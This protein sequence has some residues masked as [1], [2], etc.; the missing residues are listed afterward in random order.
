MYRCFPIA[1][2]LTSFAAQSVVGQPSLPVVEEV[3]WAPFRD[4]CR[5]LLQPLNKNAS[6]LPSETV[7]QLRT[8]VERNPDD[9]AAASA[10]VQRLLDA[11]CL[12][13]VH[14]NAESRV[15]ATR[16]PAEI[17]LQVDRPALVL[18]KV[19]NE[20]GV[21]HSLRL[22]GPGIVRNGQR[23]AGRWL[24]AALVTKTPLTPELTGRRLEYRLLCLTPRQS[25]KREATFQFDVG[26]GTQDLGFRAEVPVL[27]S[28]HKK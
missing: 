9:P 6:A 2:M 22:Y 12:I 10:A 3:E 18:L 27:F 11:H 21:T 8:L 13:A 14:I 25:G 7:R 5:R 1:L 20:G 26:Q 23:D 15:K 17:E 24:E 4:H 28:I 19:H 16:G